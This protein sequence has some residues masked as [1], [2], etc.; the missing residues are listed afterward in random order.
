MRKIRIHVVGFTLLV[1][2]SCV[3]CESL[4]WR[5]CWGFW[6]D[7]GCRGYPGWHG[8]PWKDEYRLQPGRPSPQEGFW[9]P[10]DSLNAGKR[11]GPFSARD[12]KFGG[13]SSRNE[14][15]DRDNSR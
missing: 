5:G 6:E 15:G 13:P 14:R 12:M 8:C 1:L 2:A 11:T 10:Y 4:G 3:G 7:W 9:Q